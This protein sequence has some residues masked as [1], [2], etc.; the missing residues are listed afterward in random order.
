MRRFIARCARSPDTGPGGAAPQA[1][2]NA[3]GLTGQIGGSVVDGSK[4]A[5]PGATVTVRNTATAVTREAVTDDEGLFVF[6]NLFRRHVRPA[7]H[8]DRVQNLRG[9]GR[10]C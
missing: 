9:E 8:A 7:G 4:G 6:T 2:A 3:Q 1:R 10:S 5:I